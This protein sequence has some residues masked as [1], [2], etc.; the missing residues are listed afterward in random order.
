M[1]GPH[2]GAQKSKITISLFE[3]VS[4]KFDSLSST[5]AMKFFSHKIE[6]DYNY[7]VNILGS[8]FYR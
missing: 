4:S 5:T 7:M 6:N 8:F 2:H 3:I 1:H